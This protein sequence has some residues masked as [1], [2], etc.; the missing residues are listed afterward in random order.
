MARIEK[1]DNNMLTRI[2]KN[3]SPHKLLVEYKMA[4]PQNVKHRVTICPQ[5]PLLG[6]D[7]REMKTYITQKL[8]N[9]CS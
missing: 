3:V 4:I 9:E 2:W 5:I 6:I 1:T 8:V 7:Q